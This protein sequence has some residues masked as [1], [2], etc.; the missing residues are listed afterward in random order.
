LQVDNPAIYYG[1]NSSGYYI[2]NTGIEE[3]HYP[4]GDA[5]VYNNYSGQ[6]G[7][8]FNNIFRKLL[9]AWEL[10]DIN[11]LL[12]DY[13]RDD[14]RLQRWRSV[15]ERIRKITP[16][17]QLDQDPYLVLNNGRLF[18]I[19]DAYTTSSHFPYSQRYQNGFNY[20]RNSVK[21]VVDAY[22]GTVDYFIIDEE[23]PVLNVYDSIFPGV[24]KSM[25]E[26]PEGI[27]NQFRY[28]Q[29]LFEVQIETF[30]RYHMITPQVVY[31]QEDLWTRPNEKYGGRQ[32]IMEPYYVLARLPGEE[33]LEFMLISP[34]TPEN[35]DN[36]I[37]WMAAKSDPGNYGNL[38]VYKLPKERLIYGPAQIEARIDQDPEISRQI[39]LWDQ[40]GSRV[41]RGNL[42]VIPVE[43]SFLYVEPVF[44][45]AEG[46]D[47]PQL[48]R[49]IVAIGDDISMQPSLDQA[50]YELFGD[51]AAAIVEETQL[52][53]DDTVPADALPE[54]VAI[55]R[56]TLD[57]IRSVWED[58][59]SALEEG[60]WTR[61]GELLNELEEKINNL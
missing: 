50:L 30:S 51:E 14:S 61:Y 39:A 48:Q 56:Q 21:I 4:D 49:V 46:V 22:E 38:V 36:M 16:F 24:F 37:S 54:G 33:T 52:V 40:R 45:L 13:I 41:I 5:N 35:R 18:W 23:D 6:G 60:N 15:Q 31:N 44:L 7:I 25:D 26:L 43:N 59:K 19:Q 47:I 58:L 55:D 27:E 3:L 2:V 10:G 42:M 32:L 17:L 20:I 12:T 29:D 8:Q 1:E 9:F 28:P 11:I 57:E 34:L 53:R